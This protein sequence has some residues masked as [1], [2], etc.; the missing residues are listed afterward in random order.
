MNS[1]PSDVEMDTTAQY[2]AQISRASGTSA[3]GAFAVVTAGPQPA[4]K[5]Q[6]TQEEEA[7]STMEKDAT[8]I[9]Y[10]LVQVIECLE[11][12]LT[13]TKCSRITKDE[14]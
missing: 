8:E 5:K 1:P 13:D 14:H 9:E 11:S 4:A 2:L 6:K 12:N 7:L 10:A 3:V